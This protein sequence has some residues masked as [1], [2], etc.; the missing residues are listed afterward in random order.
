MPHLLLAILSLSTFKVDGQLDTLSSHSISSEDQKSSRLTEYS[1]DANLTSLFDEVD[2]SV[3]QIS[4][5]R[6]TS[7]G[8]RQGSGFIYDNLGHIVTNYHV[9]ADPQKGQE[10]KLD[11]REFHV[12]FLDGTTQIGRVIGTGSLL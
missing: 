4:D 5:A 1:L 9:V 12:T 11:G 3:V 7:L 10:T 2:Q 8:S 6:T